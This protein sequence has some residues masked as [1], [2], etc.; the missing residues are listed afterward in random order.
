MRLD[1]RPR[2]LNRHLVR[3][4]LF[5]RYHLGLG[6]HLNDGM[7]A[8]FQYDLQLRRPLVPCHFLLAKLELSNIYRQCD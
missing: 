1:S 5:D 8:R 2:N 6:I 3:N 7:D 4:Y